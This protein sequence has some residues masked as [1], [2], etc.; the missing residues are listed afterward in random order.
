MP[1]TLPTPMLAAGRSKGTVQA[2]KNATPP[3]IGTIYAP[4]SSAINSLR[5]VV[6]A[7]LIGRQKCMSCA[8][9]RPL[10]M[11]RSSEELVLDAESVAKSALAVT[12][13]EP[14]SSSP[15]V[16]KHARME[17]VARQAKSACLC[18]ALLVQVY[19]TA[20]A[21]KSVFWVPVEGLVVRRMLAKPDT[22]AL[23]FQS[24]GMYNVEVELFYE[25]SESLATSAQ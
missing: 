11:N 2:N 16:D 1:N 5:E 14:G 22:T 15:L 20:Y 17:D 10:E 4:M 12:D 6:S 9:C 13:R 7:K 21:A 19:E 18:C 25:P 3:A 8:I 23:Q 24:A